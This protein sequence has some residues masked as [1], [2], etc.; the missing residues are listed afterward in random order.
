M[1]PTQIFLILLTYTCLL[2]TSNPTSPLAS[3]IRIFDSLFFLTDI[4]LSSGRCSVGT[5]KTQS[6]HFPGILG[7]FLANGLSGSIALGLLPIAK[8]SWQRSC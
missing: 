3:H 1:C 8:P 2:S 5:A 4:F 7:T 6:H